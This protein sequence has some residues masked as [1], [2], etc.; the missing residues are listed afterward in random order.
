MFWPGGHFG[1]NPTTSAQAPVGSL[2]TSPPSMPPASALVSVNP[3]LFHQTPP[4]TSVVVSAPS[5]P[6]GFAGS[7]AALG[8][9][10]NNSTSFAVPAL[11]QIAPQPGMSAGLP[12]QGMHLYSTPGV[13]GAAGVPPPSGAYPPLSSAVVIGP[14]FHP[15][16]YKLVAAITSGEFVDL[17]ALLRTPADEP[18]LPTISFDG[19]LIISPATRRNRRN[20]D[21]I[22]WV[23]AFG[24]Y[25]L[26]LSSYFPQRARDLLT[27]QLLILRTYSQFGGAAWRHYDEAFRRD[28]AARGLSDWSHMN[29]ELYNFHT[30]NASRFGLP[31]Q[32]PSAG[33][34]DTPSSRLVCRSWNAGSCTA[35]RQPCRYR[36]VCS[37]ISCGGPHRRSACPS[38]FEASA[39]DSKRQRLGH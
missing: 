2:A 14:G 33:E 36:H 18:T 12:V 13:G 15:I 11:G 20:L 38:R 21:I 16:P 17:A 23:Q 24:V 32:S 7:M 30:A 8:D 29:V 6:P 34:S 25:T 35:P 9:G 22:P 26:V 1:G 10:L 27:Y 3:Y 37:N 31:S 19:R 39:G 5:A 28:A 4:G